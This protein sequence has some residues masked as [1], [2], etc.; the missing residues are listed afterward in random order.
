PLTFAANSTGRMSVK[1]MTVAPSRVID[2]RTPEPPVAIPCPPPTALNW[3]LALVDRQFPTTHEPATEPGDPLVATDAP[4]DVPPDDVR[5]DV[6][7][8]W[9][10]VPDPVDVQAASPRTSPATVTAAPMI[11]IGHSSLCRSSQCRFDAL[12]PVHPGPRTATRRN[13][14]APTS[15]R[16]RHP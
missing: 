8:D 7:G 11:R 15:I 12:I 4:D 16:E 2:N 1:S 14:M 5:P 13:P 3:M 6:A 10:P 9:P